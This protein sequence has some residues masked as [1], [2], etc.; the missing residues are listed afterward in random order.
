MRDWRVTV[1]SLAL[2]TV[3]ATRLQTQQRADPTDAAAIQ[4]I[5]EEASKRSQLTSTVGTLTDL[6]GPRL[7]G[8]PNLKA[9]ADYVIEKLNGWGLEGAGPELWGPFGPGWSN[10]RFSALAVSPLA[11]PLIAY[12]KAWTPGTTGDVRAEAVVARIERDADFEKYRGKLRDRFVLTPPL[13]PIGDSRRDAADAL[14]FA[15]RRM[16]FFVTEGVAALL[17][18]GSGK[19]GAVFVG[20]GRVTRSFDA[21]MYPWPDPVPPQ[22]VL[23]TEH[24]NWIARTLEKNVPVVLEMSIANTYYTAEPNSFNIIAEIRGSEHPDQ[25][26]MIGAHLDSMHVGTG[27]I[28][29]A[30]GCAVVLEAM[31]ILKATRLKMR[32]TVRLALWSGSEQG[33][34]GSRAYVAQHFMNPSTLQARAAHSTLSAYFNVDDGTGPFRGIYV[35]GNQAVAPIFEQWMV[36]FTAA[37]MTKVSLESRA[38]KDH[39]AFDVA[40]LN[41]FHFMQE[42]ADRG[43]QLGRSNFDLYDLLEPEALVQNA[44]IVASFAF[45]AANRAE[46][47]PRKPA[48]P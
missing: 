30:A 14:A 15:R 21:G 32:R 31:R 39:V 17:D 28:D 9:A 27:A 18:P 33:S 23:A 48:S 24:F 16:E 46:P 2:V 42:G 13:R 12:P 8:S 11:F 19:S 26:V 5:T 29:N 1:A 7:T 4:Q 20:D 43:D 47:L 40:G 25:V 38:G 3:A 34:L 45:S 37:G 10:D 6:Y 35:Q 36:P 22:V 41:G 44:A